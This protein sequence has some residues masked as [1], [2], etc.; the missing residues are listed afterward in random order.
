MLAIA[1]HT[2]FEIADSSGKRLA[3]APARSFRSNR[4]SQPV[5]PWTLV[6]GFVNRE[7]DKMYLTHDPLTTPF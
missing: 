1:L 6:I 2:T 3:G 4:R 7:A 5:G